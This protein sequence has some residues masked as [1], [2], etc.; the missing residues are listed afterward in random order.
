MQRL[1]CLST[2]HRVQQ[3]VYRAKLEVINLI[4]SLIMH[5]HS[6]GEMPLI[7]DT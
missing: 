4:S 1:K 2:L 7:V 5:S 6:F 3:K